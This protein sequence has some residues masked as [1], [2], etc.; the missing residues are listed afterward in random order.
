MNP[1]T[2]SAFK[3]LHAAALAPAALDLKTKE[4]IA[5]ACGVSRLCDGCIVHH[6]RAAKAAGATL[7][8][9]QDTL[10]VCVLMGGGPATIYGKKA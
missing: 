7:A 1:A 2:A 6:T 3:G 8:E 4:L 9:I 10:D 5:I